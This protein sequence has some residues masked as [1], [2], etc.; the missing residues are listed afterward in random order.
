MSDNQI[1]FKQ[2]P[3]QFIFKY[4][5]ERNLSRL[6]KLIAY[7]V[8]SATALLIIILLLFAINDHANPFTLLWH[9]NGW[10]RLIWFSSIGVIPAI[11]MLSETERRKGY[12]S[13]D[14]VFV[15]MNPVL[16]SIMAQV[17]EL[18]SGQKRP[19]TAHVLLYLLTQTSAMQTLFAKLELSGES[20]T[21]GLEFL[22]ES[23]VEHANINE[24]Q[25]DSDTQALVQHS[26]Q[27]ALDRGDSSFGVADVFLSYLENEPD[28]AH[29]FEKLAVTPERFAGI[30]G[31]LSVQDHM[32]QTIHQIRTQRARV[33]Q[34]NR[35]WTSIPTPGMNHFAYD[36]TYAAAMGDVPLITVRENEIEQA[37][38]V[39]GR[40]TKNSLL[41]IGEVGVGK[42]SIVKRVALRMV[43][44]NVPLPLQ[45]KRLMHL[46]TAALHGAPGGFAGAFGQVLAEAEQAGNI[47]LFISNLHDLSSDQ[48]GGAAGAELLLPILER[49]RMQVIG[50]TSYKEYH[51]EIEGNSSF[52]QAFDIV[53]VKELSEKDSISV[54]EESTMQFE[55]RYHVAI[56]LKAIEAAVHL[57]TQYVHDRVLPDKAIDLLDETAAYVA[58]AKRSLV[59]EADVQAVLSQKTNI[60]LTTVGQKEEDLLL[61][62]EQELHNRVI[63]QDQAVRAVATALRRARAGLGDASRPIGSFLFVGPTGVGKTELA[64]ALAQVYFKGEDTMVRIDMSEFQD[65]SAVPRLVGQG[66]QEGLLTTPVRTHPFTLILLDEFEKSSPEIRNLF[67]Q[68][69]DDGRLTDGAGHVVD[70]KT[71]III[72]TSNAGSL[73]I[74]KDIEASMAYEEIKQQLISTIL[75]EL[76]KP[77]LLN[78]FDDIIVFKTLSA[79]EIL[80]IARLE[81]DRLAAQAKKSSGIILEVTDAAVQVLAQA[82]FDPTFGG[83]PLRRVIQDRLEAPLARKMLEQKIE[84]G[85]KVVM[86]VA[87]LA[88][89][90]TT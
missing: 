7:I 69:L 78:R 18:A 37:L 13:K 15:F 86:D 19:V 68:I 82:G 31:W 28:V 9:P 38:R 87:D 45:D 44:D 39:L 30:V 67:L 24:P 22:L 62:L 23:P 47:I 25:F 57:S 50:A 59:G 73:E 54:L 79:D 3:A 40:A 21:T 60:P 53:E 1:T 84:R 12:A 90:A 46:D 63:G 43:G 85:Q 14:D 29:Y 64:K 20:V 65:A 71:T 55:H 33:G 52:S 2:T 17:L 70:F 51:E 42:E 49:Q 75:P 89:P 83:R 76:F 32:F 88:Q 35:A 48:G 6:G 74:Q 77:E 11:Y 10:V 8:I 81:I 34:K 4:K 5:A 36:M 41:L 27:R 61:N 72:A 66:D 80:S 56:S 58:N 16:R 26:A